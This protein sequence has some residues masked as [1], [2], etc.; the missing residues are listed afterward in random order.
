M[1]NTIHCQNQTT[2]PH[3]GGGKGGGLLFYMLLSA[4]LLLGTLSAKAQTTDSTATKTTMIEGAAPKWAAK[5]Q[6]ALVSIVSYD[7]NQNMLKTGTAVYINSEG[8]AVTDCELLKGAYSAV[9][10]DAGGK[11][12]NVT[13]ILGVDNNYGLVKIATE[14]K[15]TSP[16]SF[17][18]SAGVL[19]GSRVYA[20]GYQ[21]GKI[22][23]CPMTT[24]L[25]RDIVE[26]KYVYYTLKDAF[27]PKYNNGVLMSETGELLG[28][29]L[30]PVGGNSQAVDARMGDDLTM[31]AINSKNNSLALQNIHISKAIPDAEEEALVYLYFQ[32]RSASNEDYIDMLNQFVERFPNNA[33][34]YHRRATPLTDMCRF[35]EA[36]NDL[37]S[38]LRLATD[39]PAA[40]AGVAEIIYT[41]LLYQPT[42]AYD[43]WTYDLA[44]DY[45]NQAISGEEKLLSGAA[46]D[47][48][49]QTI[50]YKVL[51]Y[52]LQKAQILMAKGDAADA[53]SIYNDING[54]K[55]RSP[56]TL[57]AA[58][59]A[60][61]AAGD[62]TET[63]IQLLDSAI[64]MFS[65]P[66]PTEASNYIMRRGQLHAAR[67]NYRQA[68]LDYNQYCYLNNNKVN[69]KFYYERYSLEVK[70]RM[71]QQALDDINLAI[72]LAPRE[73]LYYVEKSALLLRVNELDECIEAARKCLIINSQMA[74]AYR[75]MGFAQIQKGD[76]DAALKNL[77]KAKELGDESAEEIIEKYLNNK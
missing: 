72:D 44:I 30:S 7:Q 21:Q 8:H 20:L 58:S 10:V 15:K 18:Q 46:G 31:H 61:E 73:A 70:A 25:K 42:P 24:V 37:K 52:R 34:G 51:E 53:L 29:V 35:D 69:A 38:Y 22:T 59:L 11:K 36:D 75:I 12:Y 32:S 60:Y 66:L 33:E 71:Y 63:A 50:E 47:S 68:V 62:T 67:G 39:K 48:A 77:Q 57:F 64:A 43:K 23:T 14:Q 56:A 27:L 55:H 45:M 2:P 74:D 9:V 6:K 19:A 26:D 76:N 5:A 1:Q 28:I 3:A 40:N 4:L 16:I 54:G 13:R 49:V 65:T 17:A 41:K